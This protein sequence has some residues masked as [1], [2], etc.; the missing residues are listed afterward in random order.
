MANEKLRDHG[1]VWF[2]F[3]AASASLMPMEEKKNSEMQKIF[4]RKTLPVSG[5]GGDRV[6]HQSMLGQDLI[7]SHASIALQK[8]RTNS[9]LVASEYGSEDTVFSLEEDFISKDHTVAYRHT[10][11]VMPQFTWKMNIYSLNLFTHQTFI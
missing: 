11:A 7:H 10:K 2:D 1:F 4:R 6:W 9:Y 3:I 8:R 5:D